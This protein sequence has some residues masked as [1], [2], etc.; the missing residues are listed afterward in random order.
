MVLD[1][2][3]F[4]GLWNPSHDTQ[5]LSDYNPSVPGS[6]SED[7]TVGFVSAI[8]DQEARFPL[9]E[10]TDQPSTDDRTSATGENLLEFAEGDL[11]RSGSVAFVPSG[12]TLAIFHYAEIDT[13]SAA[14]DS[15]H[16]LSG[17]N[18]VQLD[19]D[20][21][22]VF[23]G[24][25]NV[26]NIV[27]DVSFDAGAGKPFSGP[28]ITSVILN[29]DDSATLPD[30]FYTV[31]AN[32]IQQFSNTAYTAKLS[33]TQDAC[34]MTNR[35]AANT[36]VGASGRIGY[37]TDTSDEN[38][39]RWEGWLAHHYSG[40]G[41]LNSLPRSHAFKYLPPRLGEAVEVLHT[42]ADET[43]YWYDSSNEP[44]IDDTTTAGRVDNITSGLTANTASQ[45]TAADKPLTG[46]GASD[47]DGLNTMGFDGVTYFLDLASGIDMT[48]KVL[49]VTCVPDV[50]AGNEALFGNSSVN[51]QLRIN[52]SGEISYGA[53]SDYWGTGNSTGSV[54]AG[55]V[56]NLSWSCDSA[57]LRL[58]VNGDRESALTNGAGSSTTF[59]QIGAKLST[60]NVFDGKILE[61]LIVDSNLSDADF[62]TVV[63][64]M[65]WRANIQAKLPVSS[66]YT[67]KPPTQ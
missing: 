13:V 37:S 48:D 45:G 17:V 56:C 51:A 32:G 15:L 23:N 50:L 55:D 36:L 25:L 53:L 9:E 21:T 46:V 40:S 52:S 10:A 42:P 14:T 26:S 35:A 57:G 59:D 58:A 12:A 49:L 4:G 24:R 11:L 65:M 6:I 34:L 63:S 22:S 60:S 39:Y 41:N 31:Y 54:S 7:D 44:T 3:K 29:W 19:A 5:R 33:E 28:I 1:S 47:V 64:D 61:F 30:S 16:C 2:F 43:G 38:R 62:D 8:A 27:A 18:N 67:E 66:A 20:N